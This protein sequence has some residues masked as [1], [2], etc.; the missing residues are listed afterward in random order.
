MTRYEKPIRRATDE[1][2]AWI[3]D[4]LVKRFETRDFI[5]SIEKTLKWRILLHVK[6]KGEV[7]GIYL[8]FT[9]GRFSRPIDLPVP[10]KEIAQ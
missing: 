6:C 1:E 9:T 3:R 5:F 7:I 4:R 8:N 10:E 2:L